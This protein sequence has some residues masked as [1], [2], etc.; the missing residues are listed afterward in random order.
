MC[1]SIQTIRKLRGCFSR[2]FGIDTDELALLAFV[3]E[4]NEALDQ[5][6]QRVVLSAT[7][8][9]AGLP[10]GATLT[11]KYVA[12]EHVLSAKFL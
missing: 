11:S 12:A 3:F 8:I 4:L 2:Q 6:E 7:D 9:L 1:F 10:F 5:R